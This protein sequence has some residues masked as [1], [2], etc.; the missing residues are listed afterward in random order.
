MKTLELHSTEMKNWLEGQKADLVWIG[1]NKES[2]NFKIDQ[3][4]WS[5]LKNRKQQ[6]MKKSELCS[7][8]L[9]K[10]IKYTNIDS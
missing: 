5:N 10:I 1:K 9:W 7:R 8:N 4:K 3:Q 6:R 2:V